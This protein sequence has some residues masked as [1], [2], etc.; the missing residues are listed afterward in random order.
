MRD[1]LRTQLTVI[2]LG[3][4]ILPLL[5]S[6]LVVAQQTFQAQEQQILALERAMV[7][8]VTTA[9]GSFVGAVEGQLHLALEVKGLVALSTGE[10]QELLSELLAYQ[11]AFAELTL[12]NRDGRE[13]V[14]ISRL[15]TY[16]S[17]DLGSRTGAPEYWAPSRTGQVYYSP[18][19]FDQVLG[20][21]IITIALPVLDQTTGE[22]RGVLVGDARLKRVWDVIAGMPVGQGESV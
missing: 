17:Q 21:P 13:L 15:R 16:R 6:G 4:A 10:Q 14:R 12:L 5:L 1:S 3:L 8:R 2:L 22:L 9:V 18:V 19:R 11:D 7:Q 20:E